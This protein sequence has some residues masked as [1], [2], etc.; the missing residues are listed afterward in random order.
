MGEVR[1]LSVIKRL[2]RP[3]QSGGIRA[4]VFT[5][6]SGSVGAGILSLP[7]VMSYFGVVTGI[8]MIIIN[9]FLAYSSYI[10]LFG[11]I[12]DSGKKRYPNLCNYYLGR[13]PAQM[14][15]FSIILFQ[16]LSV[17][18]YVCIGRGG[19]PRL[20]LRAEPTRSVRAL[21]VRAHHE[22]TNRGLRNR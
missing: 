13:K 22:P 5:L 3:L 12:I 9:A 2:A 14:F 18:I 15:A 11:A 19:S 17:T 21:P 8:A 7:L 16:F 4:A 20:E 10:S 1:K 6:F